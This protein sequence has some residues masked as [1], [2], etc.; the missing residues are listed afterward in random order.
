[1]ETLQ[2]NFLLTPSNTLTKKEKKKA[3]TMSLS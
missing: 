2:N 3:T 1:M